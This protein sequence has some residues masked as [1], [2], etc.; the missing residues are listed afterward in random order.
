MDER[1]E[2]KDGIDDLKNPIT[3]LVLSIRHAPGHR[4]FRPR[5]VRHEF[6]ELRWKVRTQI[7]PGNQWRACDSGLAPMR[8]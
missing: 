8:L 3:K 7:I 5:P 2:D 4:Q 6:V 1:L